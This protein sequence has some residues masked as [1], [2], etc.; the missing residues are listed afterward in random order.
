MDLMQWLTTDLN[1]EFLLTLLVSMVP[2]VELRGG[3]PFGVAAGLPVWAAYLAAVIGNLLPVPFIVVYIR[4]IFMFAAGKRR[5]FRRVS[6]RLKHIPASVGQIFCFRT[7]ARHKFRNVRQRIQTILRPFLRRFRSRR[8]TA[9]AGIRFREN[10]IRTVIQTGVA[11]IPGI[12]R[13]VK[14]RIQFHSLLRKDSRT[15]KSAGVPFFRRTRFCGRRSAVCVPGRIFFV[16]NG[17]IQFGAGKRPVRRCRFRRFLKQ[18]RQKAFQQKTGQQGKQDK[19]YAKNQSPQKHNG[20]G[21]PAQQAGEEGKPKTKR[22]RGYVNFRHRH[23]HLPPYRLCEKKPIVK[24]FS[25][26]CA[27]RPV[28]SHAQIYADMHPVRIRFP[29]MFRKTKTPV[30]GRKRVFGF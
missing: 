22:A 17:D 3:I 21:G 18:F 16:L 14:T 8:R 7:A 11:G 24:L 15:G 12:Q 1:G 28:Y 26:F 6:V 2:V 23:S 13:L 4:R 30:S 20:K 27:G 9:G 5:I 10:R 25:L 19:N 29:G